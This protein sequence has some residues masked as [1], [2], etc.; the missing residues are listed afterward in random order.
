MIILISHISELRQALN[1]LHFMKIVSRTLAI[2]SLIVLTFSGYGQNCNSTSVKRDKESGLITVSGIVTS[3]DFYSL[4]IQKQISIDDT[5]EPPHYLL[6]LN[7]ASRVQFSDSTLTTKG[8]L[9]LTLSDSSILD[10]EEVSFINRPLGFKSLGF[11]V[12]VD[13]KVIKAL[14]AKPI[15]ILVVDDKLKTEFKLKKQKEQKKIFSCLLQ[16]NSLR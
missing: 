2:L 3:N 12:Y 16:S 8:R 5:T 14:A 13:E 15:A 10:L 1:T 6:F 4:L 11:R 7:A 9:H